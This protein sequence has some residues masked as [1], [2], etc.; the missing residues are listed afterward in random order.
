MC[1]EWIEL[2]GRSPTNAGL[3]RPARGRFLNMSGLLGPCRNYSR[4]HPLP[5]HQLGL[6]E[7]RYCAPAEWQES[8]VPQSPNRILN[9]LPQN[10]FAAMEPHLRN[11][12]LVFGEVIAEPGE[13]VAHVYF[14]FSGVV[15]LV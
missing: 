15:S 13:A 14:P 2:L 6:T 5:L 11:A 8:V 4:S 1:P 9:A 3:F 10:I 12:P 7:R